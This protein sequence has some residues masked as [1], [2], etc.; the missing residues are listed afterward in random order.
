MHLYDGGPG[1]SRTRVQSASKFFSYVGCPYLI[2]RA[3]CPLSLQ[4]V[5][6][7]FLS[8]RGLHL[9]L[10]RRAC[11]GQH[12]SYTSSAQPWYALP[13]G[14]PSPLNSAGRMVSGRTTITRRPPGRCSR[15]RSGQCCWHLSFC[16]VWPGPRLQ[17][18]VLILRPVET[19]SGPR[20]KAGKWDLNPHIRGYR[21]LRPACLPFHHSPLSVFCGPSIFK[22]SKVPDFSGSLRSAHRRASWL[23]Y[24]TLVAVRQCQGVTFFSI[25]PKP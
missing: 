17:R 19:L 1:G 4:G 21:I 14:R 16:P 9:R 23:F 20:K 10:K 11:V 15:S 18:R 22:L 5:C 7:Q 2:Q 6:A 25:S 8:W 12:P 3:G 13:K 24:S